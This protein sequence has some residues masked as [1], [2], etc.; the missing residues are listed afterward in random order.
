MAIVHLLQSKGI[1]HLGGNVRLSRFEFGQLVAQI[2]G[3]PKKL[4]QSASQQDFEMAAA[5]PS[6][7]SLNSQKLADYGFQMNETA[8]ELHKLRKIMPS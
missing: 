4:I 1:F 8:A 6:D 5:R 3:I 7:T 2:F